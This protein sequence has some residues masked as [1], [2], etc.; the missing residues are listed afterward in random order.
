MHQPKPHINAAYR[1]RRE[2]M[3]RFW[4]PQFLHPWWYGEVSLLGTVLQGALVVAACFSGAKFYHGLGLWALPHLK[5]MFI[6]IGLGVHKWAIETVSAVLK[7]AV[8]PFVPASI[9]PSAAAIVFWVPATLIAFIAL[10]ATIE[11]ASKMRSF[12]VKSFPEKIMKNLISKKFSKFW[13]TC[14][15]WLV[16]IAGFSIG[17]SYGVP[18]NT[19]LSGAGWASALIGSY[20]Q[21]FKPYFRFTMVDF[22]ALPPRQQQ[23][24]EVELESEEESDELELDA[25]EVEQKQEL[26]QALDQ[27]DPGHPQEDRVEQVDQGHPKTSL[28]QPE[29]T[30]YFAVKK[31]QVAEQRIEERERTAR[32]RTAITQNEATQNA[33]KDKTGLTL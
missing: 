29:I 13:Y 15:A 9:V 20:W 24:P 8:L 4:L 22:P 7:A 12:N 32:E 23:E 26:D 33:D 3:N 25:L 30:N 2:A 5:K 16:P 28:R 1:A 21:I 27:V 31:Q 6:E 17:L 19:A 11:T 18:M 14:M 10:S